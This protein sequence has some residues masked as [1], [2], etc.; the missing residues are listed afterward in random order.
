MGITYRISIIGNGGVGGAVGKVFA[1]YGYQVIFY[2]V[3]QEKRKGLASQG[4]EV[5]GELAEAVLDTDISFICVPT[6]TENG[7][8]DRSYVETAL[9]GVLEA[10]SSKDGYHTIA[11]K[12]TVLP[13]IVW[14][15]NG[16]SSGVCMNPE[17]LRSET[18]EEDFE[19]Q[20]I[21]IG[22][23]DQKATEVLKEF[24]EDFKRRTR[25]DFEIL[26]TDA[27]TAA[28][29]KYASNCLLAT[30]ISLFNEI[31]GMCGKLGV[32]PGVVVRNVIADRHSTIEFYRRDF[33]SLGFQ[34]EC[35]PKDLEAF[36]SFCSDLNY[37][38]ELL[39]AVKKV[40]ERVGKQ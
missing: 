2:D 39:R 35:L 1:K 17:F 33:L 22:R 14:E 19:N 40:N 28:M 34:D 18:A 7:R 20:P 6:P 26:V 37:Q 5:A 21:I 31:A 4:Y 12:S 11:I 16:A 23:I 30:K 38:P 3:D 32:D 25:K 9:A 27:T 15:S 36:I 8:L 10:A 24:Y 13:G 29:I